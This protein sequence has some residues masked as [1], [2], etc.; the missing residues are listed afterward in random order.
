M[1]LKRDSSIDLIL[2]DIRIPNIDGYEATIEI[3]KFDKTIPI[4]AQSWLIV[5]CFSIFVVWF[6]TKILKTRTHFKNH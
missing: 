5:K 4:I 2:M 1:M 6:I 3:R